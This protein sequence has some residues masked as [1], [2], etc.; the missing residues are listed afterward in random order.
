MDYFVHQAKK[1]FRELEETLYKLSGLPSTEES[2][3]FL[4]FADGVANLHKF[5]RR[6]T[7][8]LESYTEDF[9]EDPDFEKEIRDLEGEELPAE[10]N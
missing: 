10:E 3:E 8:E 2:D 1:Q 4:P 6:R 7:N 5:F 9:N